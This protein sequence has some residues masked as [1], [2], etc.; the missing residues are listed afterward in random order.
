MAPK[1]LWVARTW[2]LKLSIF[3]SKFANNLVLRSLAV[4]WR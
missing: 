4:S 2:Q 3:K 1:E